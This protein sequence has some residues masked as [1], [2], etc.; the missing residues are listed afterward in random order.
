[1][2]RFDRM[3]AY[4][5]PGVAA[6]REHYRRV[7]AYYEAAKK[8]DQRKMRKEVGSPDTPVLRAGRSLREQARHLE[9]NHDLARGALNLMVTNIVGPA[10]I[11]VEPQPKSVAGEIHD[12][13]VSQ[14]RRLWDD[15][16]WTPEVTWFHDWAS[17]QRIACRA[18]IRD[19]E[20]LAQ[21]LE[22]EIPSLNH[23]TIVPF[24]L[25]LL[26][27]DLLPL[28]YSRTE[29]TNQRE[30]IA[31]IERNA[32]GRPMTF[33]VYR[34]HPAD[35]FRVTQTAD[36]KGVPAERMIHVKSIDRIRQ[37]RGVSVFAS[38]LTRL[39]DIK[40]YE[41]SE[42]VA[43]KISA[44][45]AAFIKKGPADAWNPESAAEEDRTMPFRAGMIFDDLL[46]GEDVGVIST[47]RPNAQLEPHRNGQ[48][49][50]VA[51]G[52]GTSYSSLS[53]DYSGT[54]SAQRQELVESWGVYQSLQN[55]F[56]TQ[57]VRPVYDKFISLAVA[58]R[59]LKIP[60]DLDP[61]TLFSAVYVGPQIPW[62]DPEKEANAWGV[63]EG[64]AHA[65]GPEIIRRRGMNP[66]DV[67]DSEIRWRKQLEEAGIQT[68]LTQANQ[69]DKQR[70]APVVSDQR[71]RTRAG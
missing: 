30:I 34:K 71:G 26:E 54:Y 18:W 49:R 42:R 12:G 53:K 38:V 46:P 25:E 68:S 66:K 58:A 64:N 40:D 47:S 3:V 7:L 36:L 56:V 67:L 35:T 61:S 6:K 60:A 37:V 16:A 19:G 23:G 1:M 41:E 62:I 70:A 39:D 15:W 5:A 20:M 22:G 21:T 59:A 52:M 2:N 4:F 55:E 63:L 28:E 69:N 11:Q 51:A 14:I 9:Q 44:S 65:S 17:V 13:F 57:F 8:S 48:L 32:W 31:G 24:S 27:A 10:G 45:M 33:W 50:A 43:A 29:G